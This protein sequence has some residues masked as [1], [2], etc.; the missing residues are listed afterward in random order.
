MARLLADTTPLRVSPEFRRLWWGLGLSNFG[1]QL[2]V[3]AVGLQVYAVSGST[4]AVGVLGICALV[5]LVVFGL[6]GGSLVDAHDRRTVALNAQVGLALVSVLIALQ[7]WLHVGSIGLLYSLVAVQSALVAINNPAQ[8]AIIPQLVSPKLLPAA[9]ALQSLAWNV[10]LTL[11]PLAGAGLVAASGYQAAYTIDAVTFIAALW[12]LW[13]LPPLPP[14]RADDVAKHRAGLASVL[15]GLRYLATRPNL[16]MTFLVDLSAMILAQPRV[17]FPAAGAVILGGGSTT[18]GALIAAAA[19]G[20]VTATALSGP[21]TRVVAQGRVIA[22]AVVGWGLSIAAF[23]AVL[24]AAGHR[25]RSGVVW[26]LLVAA[27]VFLAVAGAA[28]AVSAVFRTTI[29]Q[30]ATPDHMRGRLQGVFI[31]VVAGGPRLGEM[32]GGAGSSFV[33]EGWV[34]AC[35]GLA[36]VLAVVLLMRWQPRF[37]AYD[38][39]HP[40]P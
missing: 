33:G 35:G 8:S 16:R 10:A 39:R 38:A 31:V 29:L 28:D 15:E 20:A 22:W 7:A 13:R 36:C 23:G 24:V 17:M 12:A 27:L 40:E 37:L 1:S 21:L 6:Y 3:V 26:N 32:F 4:L 25:G 2:T 9:N 34:A 5:P 19:F 11:G 30:A 14:T 18:T